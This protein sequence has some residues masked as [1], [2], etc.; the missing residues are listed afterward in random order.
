MLRLRIVL[1]IFLWCGL[2]VNISQAQSEKSERFKAIEN[3]KIAFIAKE[4]NL[5]T[6]E[7]QKFFPLYNQY[8][9]EMWDVR[10]AKARL[11]ESKT[12]KTAPAPKVNSFRS[13]GN[14][15]EK[16]NILAYD[17]QEVEIKK[18]YWEKFSKVIVEARSSE[19][20]E[21]EQRFRESLIKELKK[22]RERAI[23]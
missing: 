10:R 1:I 3:E 11:K 12:S 23:N 8:S 9:N 14:G 21:V 6:K 15:S 2:L 18:Q 4:L 7:A 13:N 20:F 5:S 22:R 16:K 17:D 19:F